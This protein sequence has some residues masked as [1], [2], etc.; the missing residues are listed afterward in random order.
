MDVTK[1]KTLR[2]KTGV[3]ISDCREALE[4]NQDDLVKAEAWLKTQGIKK[5]DKKA[6]RA[7][8]QGSITSYVHAGKIG[9]LVEL[10]CETDFVAKTADFTD[11]AHEIA[12]QISA[13]APKDN[14][15]L[16]S[17][18]YIRDPKMTVG[19]LVK[20][21]IAKLGENIKIGRFTRLTLG[22]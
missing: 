4:K 21:V 22:E 12:L 10:F 1:I 16:L 19:D 6:D 13:M 20:S 11:L 17:Q 18:P 9:V 2:E 5:A 15:S 3:S 8:S 7:T 14:K